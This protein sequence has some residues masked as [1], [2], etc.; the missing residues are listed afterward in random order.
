MDFV[1]DSIKDISKEIDEELDSIKEK[2]HLWD[3][4]TKIEIK[5][6]EYLKIDNRK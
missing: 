5:Y 2:E 1:L 6:S 3:F 4:S